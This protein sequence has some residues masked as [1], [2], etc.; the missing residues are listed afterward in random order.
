MVIIT[1]FIEIV[2]KKKGIAVRMR[3]QVSVIFTVGVPYLEQCF[4]VNE[5]MHNDCSQ[6]TVTLDRIDGSLV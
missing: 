1:V 3:G 5:G 4:L 2:R 6:G